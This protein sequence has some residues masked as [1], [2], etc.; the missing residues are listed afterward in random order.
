MA[1]EKLRCQR[2]LSRPHR[3][4]FHVERVFGGGRLLMPA[5]GDG[6]GWPLHRESWGR[7]V[8][9]TRHHC[10][11][12]PPP[13]LGVAYLGVVIDLS[14]F[15]FNIP[16]PYGQVAGCIGD[17]LPLSIAPTDYTRIPNRQMTPRATAW[18]VALTCTRPTPG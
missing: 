1:R 15:F 13:I 11:L 7:L 4:L 5:M 10:I 9:A 14:Y 12:L 6:A 17:G 16:N 3:Q 18:I 8:G 2:G